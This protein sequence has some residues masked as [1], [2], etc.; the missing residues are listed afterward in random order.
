MM[1]TMMMTARSMGAS[2]GWQLIARGDSHHS[3]RLHLQLCSD[4]SAPNLCELALMHSSS[5]AVTKEGEG[6]TP[7]CYS[8]QDQHLIVRWEPRPEAVLVLT[9]TVHN[10]RVGLTH[11]Q[12][13]GSHQNW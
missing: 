7:G 4:V 11:H 3:S 9:K 1:M 6:V 13:R 5:V 8:D 10:G 12:Q 2:K